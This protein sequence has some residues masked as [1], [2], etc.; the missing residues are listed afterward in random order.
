MEKPKPTKKKFTDP[1]IK[2]VKPR[3]G[4]FEIWETNGRG[5]G[6]R[7]SPRGRKTWIY[8]Y[9]FGGKARRMTLGEYPEMSLAEARTAHAAAWEDFKKGIDPGAAKVAADDEA[10]KA[11]TVGKLVKEFIEK[12]LK[13]KGN[14]TWEEYKR[15]L[16]KDV[17][18][19][20]EHRKAADIKK[21]DVILLL[22]GIVDRG[23]PNQSLQVFKQIRR[24]FNF[25][26]ERDIIEYSP[27]AHVK[28]L[29]PEKKKDRFL[30][31]EEI[32]TFWDNLTACSMTDAMRR[33][34]LLI[35]LTAQ[36]PGEVIGAHSSEFD[37]CWWTIPADRSKNKRAHLVY[38][39]PL[40][41]GLFQNLGQG[42][43]FP[44]PRGEKPI[45]TNALAHALRRAIK[46]DP[47][48]K[49]RELPMEHFTPHD[50]RRTVATH[51]AAI[52]YTDE[53]IGA[54]LNHTR[55]GVTP[56]YNRHRY[57][58]EKQ[59]ALEAWERKLLSIVYEEKPDNVIELRK[60]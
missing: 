9:R 15:S 59:Q 16:E 46:R 29:V 24:M 38:L 23:S 4:R 50:L 25:A 43:L 32:K 28:A 3:E 12:G 54:V 60:T 51:L 40:A 8:M 33:A 36:R 19:A 11:P 10:R 31:T 44:S 42:Y 53:I 47:Q 49:E 26:V 41:R 22:E 7:V 48:T 20:W 18:P 52:G 45:E 13:A 58:L 39:T 14:R 6:L 56:I 30:S 34:L 57:S 55:P 1:L 37:D 35:L 17:V 5:L 21:R 27:C 2:S